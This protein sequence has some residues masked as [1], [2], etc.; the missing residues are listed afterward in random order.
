M[1]RILATIV[2]AFLLIPSSTPILLAADHNEIG[3][4]IVLGEPTG[5]NAQFFWNRDS[6]IDITAAWS[7]GDWLTVA[8]D[9]QIYN[10]LMDAP[11]EWR[12][13][14]GIGSYMTFPDD[15][16]LTLGMRIPL[17][18]KYHFPYSAIDI[19]AE[20]APG[21]ELLEDT[22]AIFHGGVGLTLWIK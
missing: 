21:I 22:E 8:G 12:W 20:A 16:D 7:L 6:A 13:Y 9:F 1:R 4:G 19:W 17:G 18:I 10:Y 2:I 11:R 5:L 14:Y 15:K 3:L